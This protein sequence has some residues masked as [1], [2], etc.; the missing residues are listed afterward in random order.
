MKT[1]LLL[2]AILASIAA[3]LQ[4]QSKSHEESAPKPDGSTQFKTGDELWAHI[5][6][7]KNGS[8]PKSKEEYIK[9]L[10][11]VQE[12]EADFLK[13]FPKDQ[14]HWEAKLE[15]ATLS[16][17]LAQLGRPGFDAAKVEAVATE[18]IGASGVPE[19][20]KR[21][22]R[23]LLLQKS[24]TKGGDA[25]LESKIAAF[26]KDY[27]NNPMSD[28]LRIKLAKNLQSSD[29]A[30]AEALLNEAAK[31]SNESLAAS[32]QSALRMKNLTA[33]PLELKFTAVDGSE[34]DLAKF[35]GKVVLL[36][37][38]ATWC[39]PCMMEVPNVVAAYQKYHGKGFEIIGISLD[40]DKEAMLK[41]TNEKGM[42]WPQ[43]FDGEGWKNKI[44]SSFGIDSIPAMWL[45]NKKGIVVNTD[46]REDLEGSLKK[47]LAE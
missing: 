17:I 30:K 40:Q 12:A 47:L 37:F 15:E 32:A 9:L 13:R 26:A 38:W 19:E 36:D 46:A 25:E 27:P 34:I 39:G 35:R 7:L 41:V 29:P 8:K 33:K 42:S 10:T 31:S 2:A 5:Q 1:L 4:A 43:Y 20:T 44:S 22:A 23:F 24:L 16:S 45:I 11:E 21:E 18:I 28:A 14:H 6:E 3:P